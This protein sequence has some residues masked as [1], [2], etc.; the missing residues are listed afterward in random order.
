MVR[1]NLRKTA[2]AEANGTPLL[3]ST[4]SPK[5]EPAALL[6]PPTSSSSSS[7]LATESKLDVK[8]EEKKDM[9][10]LVQN[11][12]SADYDMKETDLVASLKRK[13]TFCSRFHAVPH[14]SPSFNVLAIVQTDS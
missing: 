8:Q 12:S 11:G 9:T 14:L 4:D 7:S 2:L 6:S 1:S 3:S 5:P 10:T 13:V